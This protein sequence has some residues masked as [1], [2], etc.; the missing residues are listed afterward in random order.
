MPIGRKAEQKVRFELILRDYEKTKNVFSWQEARDELDGLPN[1]KGLNIAF[2]AVE[3][4]AK[5][6]R[7]T[8]LAIRWLGKSG[9]IQD[10]AS[11]WLKPTKCSENRSLRS[12]FSAKG[13]RGRREFHKSMNLAALWNFPFCSFVKTTY[14]EAIEDLLTDV[15][16]QR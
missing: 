11:A 3:R 1:D 7:S 4:H 12:A 6:G 16:T 8:K 5:S 10:F 9:D 2:E 15:Y 14:L 13:G